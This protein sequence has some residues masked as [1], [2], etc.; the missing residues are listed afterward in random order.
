MFTK[1]SSSRTG[2]LLACSSKLSSFSRSLW[3]APISSPIL[4]KSHFSSFNHK[5]PSYSSSSPI[6]QSFPFRKSI[7]IKPSGK[8]FV[9]PSPFKLLSRFFAT[10]GYPAQAEGTICFGHPSFLPFF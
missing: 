4:W 7:S 6:S 3:F 2:P 10:P 1:R 8:S 5:S 9:R